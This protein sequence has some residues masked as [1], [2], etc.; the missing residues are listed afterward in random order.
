MKRSAAKGEG[1]AAG[2]QP[3]ANEQPA[4]GR[5]QAAGNDAG[6]TGRRQEKV[7]SEPADFGGPQP[8]QEED[9]AER[10]GFDR[11]RLD[12]QD[13]PPADVR[14]RENLAGDKD[15]EL[16]PGTKP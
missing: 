1:A 8:G 15:F 9:Q 10:Q 6:A 7:R 4:A 11:Q 14:D 13:A 3:G 16:G 12:P 5:D 2:R